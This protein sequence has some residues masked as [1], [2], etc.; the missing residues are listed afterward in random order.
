MR[1]RIHAIAGIVAFAL[2]LTFWSSTLISE[3]FGSAESIAAVKVAI[4]K[5]MI[6]LVPALAIAGASGMVMGRKR[7]DAL[8]SAKKKRMPLIAMNGLLILLPSAFFLADRASAGVFDAWFFGVQ[9]LELIAGAINLSL[10]GLNIRD[11]LKMTRRIGRRPT[12]SG[13]GTVSSR[14]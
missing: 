13:T 10:I 2:I 3:I 9:T 11:G 1:T 5:A 7:T 4:L 8:A 6:V 12:R 14:M